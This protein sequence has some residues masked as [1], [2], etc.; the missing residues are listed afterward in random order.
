MQ[1]RT[2]SIRSIVIT[3]ILAAVAILLGAT[4]LGFIPVPNPSGNATIMHVPAIIAGIIAGPVSGLIVGGIF[5]LYSFLS[6]TTPFFKDPLVAI[7]PRLFIGVTAYYAYVSLRSLNRTTGYILTAI[8]AV[9][10]VAFLFISFRNI[11][12]A[13]TA[14]IIYPPLAADAPE[15]ARSLINLTGTAA[16]RAYQVIG[17]VIGLI[18]VAVVFALWRFIQRDEIEMLSVSTAAIVGTLTNTILVVT[19]LIV[20]NWFPAGVIIPSVTPQAFAEIVIAVIVTVAVV[21]GWKQMD[22]GS[23]KSSI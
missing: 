20:R 2:M 22:S 23:G 3:G 1:S 15:G 16:V 9:L 8:L 11:P 7:L 14:S 5:G 13:D 12:P 10:V 19:M 21:A 6:S 18:G 4:R 17:A